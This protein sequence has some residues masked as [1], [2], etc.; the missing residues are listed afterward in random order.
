LRKNSNSISIETTIG[1]KKTSE[2]S[3]KRAEILDIIY[4]KVRKDFDEHPEWFTY[5]DVLP[6]PT[7]SEEQKLKAIQVFM[8]GFTD[9]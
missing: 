4:K 5:T 6:T 7:L 1:L 9:E 2:G 3:D 8:G